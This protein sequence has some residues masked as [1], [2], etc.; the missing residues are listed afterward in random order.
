MDNSQRKEQR[1][2]PNLAAALR[3]ARRVTVLTGSGVSAES[4]VP[5]FRDALTGLWA[6]YNPQELA[7]PQAFRRNPKMVWE[8][9][10]E[11]RRMMQE[12]EPN[13][14]HFALA[15]MERRV[16]E[17]TLITQNVDG[18]HQRAGSVRVYELHGNLSRVK[19]SRE[20]T[21][22]EKW[23]ETGEVPP[24]C[25]GCGAFLR[26]DVVWF[27]EPLPVAA[28]HSAIAAMRNCD[29][30]LSVGTS[31]EVE[32]AASLPYEA[33][34]HG[35][36]VVEVNPDETPLSERAAFWLAG[37]SGELLPLL[38]KATWGDQQ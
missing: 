11:R 38:V 30:M 16:P 22:V 8:W 23:S 31:G 32:P 4:G 21:I 27:G 12:K 35:A 13:P 9:Y 24:R 2:H 7:T 3:N 20:D 6:N 1:I 5:T 26:P 19:C 18:L 28:M 15:E 37:P 14:G 36:T 17:F 25:P 33:L 10:A 34:A 29:V